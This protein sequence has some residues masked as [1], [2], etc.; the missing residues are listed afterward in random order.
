MKRLFP[1]LVSMLLFSAGSNAARLKDLTLVEGGR[2]NQLVGYG[3]VVG[4]AGK[5]DSQ[6]T[7]TDQ[8]IANA[9]QRF[10]VNVPASTIKSNNVAAVMVTASIA[11]FARPGSKMDVTV[12][13]IGDAQ[14][15][16]GGVLIQTPLL[17]ADDVVYARGAGLCRHRRLP[18]RQRRRRRFHRS[19][20]SP[21]RRHHQRRSAG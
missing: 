4:L 8:S 12:S 3:L 9:L 18:W 1:F 5:G 2:E 21:H 16:Q 20:E 6:L 11:P 10:G 7:Y 17:G 13:S 19:K 15:I 14:T